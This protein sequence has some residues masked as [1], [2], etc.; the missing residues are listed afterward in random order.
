MWKSAVYRLQ[1]ATEKRKE[2]K[3]G[4]TQKQQAK[5]EGRDRLF[6]VKKGRQS[7][8][9]GGV[10]TEAQPRKAKGRKKKITRGQKPEPSRADA[11]NSGALKQPP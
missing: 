8:L 11:G 10:S 2:D 1:G 6:G 5:L 3:V 9:T 7:K 4:D